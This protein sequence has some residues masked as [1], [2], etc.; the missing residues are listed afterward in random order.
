MKS[1]SYRDLI[2]WQ[3]ALTLVTAIY[4]ATDRFP[5]H[6]LYGLSSQI[7]RAAVSVASNIAEGQGRNSRGEFL[8]FL[9]HAKGSLTEVETQI[10]IACNLNYLNSK[11][12]DEMLLKSEEVSRLMAGLMK[13]LRSDKEDKKFGAGA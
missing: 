10:F 9:G 13:A 3:K 8:Q 5:K 11:E 12:R 4:R 1:Q 2:V 6:E 7:R